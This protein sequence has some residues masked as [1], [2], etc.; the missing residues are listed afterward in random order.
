[1]KDD[2]GDDCLM[3]WRVGWGLEHGMGMER[4]SGKGLEMSHDR[5]LMKMGEIDDRLKGGG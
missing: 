4:K 3:R 1:M 5:V 2:I